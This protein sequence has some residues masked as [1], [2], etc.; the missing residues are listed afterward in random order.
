LHWQV[1]VV[2]GTFTLQ[3]NT[4]LLLDDLM[5]LNRNSFVWKPALCSV[6]VYFKICKAA[7]AAHSFLKD[8]HKSCPTHMQKYGPITAKLASMLFGALIARSLACMRLINVV[9]AKLWTI[10]IP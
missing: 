10:D 7:T 9:S 8:V 2:Y 5:A 3:K 1:E 6:F 4:L